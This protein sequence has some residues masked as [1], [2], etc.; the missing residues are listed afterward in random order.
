VLQPDLLSETIVLFVVSTSG[1]GVE[2]RSMTPLWNNLLRSDLPPNIFEDLYVSVFGLGDTAYEKFC[3]AAKKLSRRLESLGACEFHVRGEGDEQHAHGGVVSHRVKRPLTSP[4]IDGA[5]QPWT[6]G[7][8]ETLLEMFPLPS[9]VELTPAN[10]IPPPRVVLE[11]ASQATHDTS[12]DPLKVDLQYHRGVV[13][14]NERITAA[15]WYQDVRRLEFEFEDNV[16]CVTIS[17]EFYECS[18]GM[19]I[20]AGGRCSHT[21]FSINCGNRCI[22]IDA[23]L[24]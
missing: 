11:P 8:L 10:V 2:P 19:Q 7:L 23:T 4:R 18:L 9:G 13:K 6:E 21:S 15:D 17:S 22:F 3:W 24:G 5:L 16:Q 1:S 20:R 14:T 12:Q